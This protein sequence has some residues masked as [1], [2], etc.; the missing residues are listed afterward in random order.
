MS[1]SSKAQDL[2][3]LADEMKVNHYPAPSLDHNLQSASFIADVINT[4]SESGNFPAL[5]S[6]YPEGAP[7]TVE[8]LFSGVRS[9]GALAF[10]PKS[11]TECLVFVTT[12]D[13]IH[14]AGQRYRMRK[15]TKSQ[16]GLY[17][18][19]RVYSFNQ[20]HQSVVCETR[21]Q[22]VKRC[23]MS[24]GRGGASVNFYFGRL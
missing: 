12:S 19:G 23:S 1:L 10:K 24:Y 21:D 13:Q 9:N 17:S 14:V 6:R 8:T 2:G 11:L 15:H 22:F 7:S 18:K 3:A 16:V 5:K 20:A 4:A